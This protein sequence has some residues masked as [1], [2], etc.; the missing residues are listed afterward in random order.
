MLA[1]A[2]GAHHVCRCRR[3]RDLAAHPAV[4]SRAS[5]AAVAVPAGRWSDAAHRFLRRCAA[6][7]NLHACYLL[8]M[9]CNR[10]TDDLRTLLLLGTANSFLCFLSHGIYLSVS[11]AAVDDSRC[12][13]TVS[14]AERRG[15]RYWRAR[16]RAGTRR[17]CTRSPWCSSTAVA[18]TRRT[19]TPAR[20]WRCARGPRGSATSLRSASSATASRTASARAA[21]P[22]PDATSCS[23]PPHASSSPRTAE[24]AKTTLPAGS[25]WSGGRCPPRQEH[26]ATA[27]TPTRACARIRGAGG[28]RRG[29]TSSVSARRAGPPSTARARARRSIG[30]A[31]TV[32]SARPQL[33]GGSPPGTRSK[34]T[35]A[36]WSTQRQRCACT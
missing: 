25:W 15:R 8:G 1:L 26:K 16:R 28:G 27:T 2:G 31:R 32:A 23:T 18:A 20:A 22:Q 12:C 17:R 7:G 10:P 33:A 35:L 34:R 21:P 13:S 3:F 6:S 24:T 29:G 5:A 9:V 14:G 36:G 4:L 30:S 19:R 11:R